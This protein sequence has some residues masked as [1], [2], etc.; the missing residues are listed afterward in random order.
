[1][2]PKSSL[3]YTR[4]LK[5]MQSIFSFTEV[6]T[7]KRLPSV[8]SSAALSGY[9]CQTRPSNDKWQNFLESKLYLG[10]LSPRNISESTKEIIKK[11]EESARQ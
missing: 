9:R 7:K 1:M 11:V 5:D 10:N 2:Q 3:D 8:K 4:S 6:K